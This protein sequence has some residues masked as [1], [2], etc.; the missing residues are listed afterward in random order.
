MLVVQERN[1]YDEQE[2][3]SIVAS[4]DM[5]EARECEEI[6]G[7]YNITSQIPRERM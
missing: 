6:L 4:L 2:I 1:K 5:V 7:E 3:T